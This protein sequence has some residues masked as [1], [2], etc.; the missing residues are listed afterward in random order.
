MRGKKLLRSGTK[1]RSSMAYIGTP[2]EHRD[3]EE[4]VFNPNTVKEGSEL[5]EEEIEEELERFA[6]PVEIVPSDS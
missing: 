4:V 2:M 1:V 5:S 6:E 3:E